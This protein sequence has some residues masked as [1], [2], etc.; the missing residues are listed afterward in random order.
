MP[1]VRYGPDISDDAAQITDFVKETQAKLRKGAKL[2]KADSKRL[3]NYKNIAKDIFG[4]KNSDFDKG[5]L[6]DLAEMARYGGS[7]SRSKAA[8]SWRTG[9]TMKKSVSREFA[10]RGDSSGRKP[11]GVGAPADSWYAGRTRSK[12]FRE[13][14]G[15][16]QRRMTKNGAQFGAA[17]IA[18]RATKPD[19]F[20][21]QVD[22]L[23]L[24]RTRAGGSDILNRP[25]GGKAPGGRV[26]G[27]GR[28][29]RPPKAKSAA[30]AVQR[31]RAK[32][33]AEKAADLAK[34]KKGGKGGGKKGKKK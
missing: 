25:R 30:R 14:E 32:T 34:G 27:A 22:K 6:G 16:A 33:G 15:R 26:L 4:V 11:G 19:N 3:D 29:I 1:G 5:K 7:K 21:S 17:K 18:P 23:N 12:R 2:S 9:G 28:P 31:Q 20:L 8:K 10:D 24:A 13:L